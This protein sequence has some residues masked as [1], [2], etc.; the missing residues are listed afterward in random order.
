[1]SDSI[2]IG[3]DGYCREHR[4]QTTVKKPAPPPGTMKIYTA[5]M[6]H[7]P[8]GRT[9]F[10]QVYEIH[11]AAGHKDLGIDVSELI[12]GS[13]ATSGHRGRRVGPRPGRTPQAPDAPQVVPTSTPKRA[14]TQDRQRSGLSGRAPPSTRTLPGSR[15]LRGRMERKG[16]E[17]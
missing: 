10:G 15:P 7:A 3:F 9:M 1:M 14:G 6:Q 11:C 4:T 8:C 5:M 17:R 12:H 2:T 16:M 13:P